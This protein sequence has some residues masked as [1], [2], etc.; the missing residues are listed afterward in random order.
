MP[1]Q[2]A[3]TGLKSMILA[4]VPGR[5]NWCQSCS[6]VDMWTPR[7]ARTFS[8]LIFLHLSLLAAAPAH[9]QGTRMQRVRAASPYLR[10]I[11]VSGVER[12]PTFHAIVD[13]LEQSDVI[14]E[15]QCGLFSGSRLAGR[16]VLLAAQ[17][18]IRYVLV[19]VGCPVTSVPALCT[20]GHE[21]RHALEIAS[22]PS[23]VDGESLAQLFT[24]IGFQSRITNP[25]GQFET[26]DAVAAGERI[27]HELFHQEDSTRR[28]A[29]DSI[30][31]RGNNDHGHVSTGTTPLGH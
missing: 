7:K 25:D 6:S 29:L 14:V 16:T 8:M 27:H 3:K 12:S 10:L 26:A 2:I 21:L 22:A 24:E 4:G 28:L 20:I 23:V 1:A 19:E 15:V 17:P 11:I 30:T 13:Q 9:A 18:S 5:L 31:K